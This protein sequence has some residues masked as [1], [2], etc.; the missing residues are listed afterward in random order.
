MLLD[1]L[2]L[3]FTFLNSYCE[4]DVEMKNNNKRKTKQKP[5][6]VH[7]IISLIARNFFLQN[8]CVLLL[9]LIPFFSLI[10]FVI[11]FHFMRAHTF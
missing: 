3:S 8:A 1:C 9:L 11:L 4:R 10:L 2:I 7:D 6:V 5:Y